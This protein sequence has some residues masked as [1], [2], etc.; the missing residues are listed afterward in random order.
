MA[1]G[2][3]AQMNRFNNKMLEL[4]LTLS[5]DLIPAFMPVI[6]LLKD[7]ADWFAKNSDIMV[8]LAVGLAAVVIGVSAWSFAQGIL[9][10]VMSA[11]PILGLVSLAILLGTF[12]WG[13]VR[14]YEGWGQSLTAIWEVIKAFG[15]MA[16]IPF[17]A[18]GESSWYHIQKLWLN[19]KDFAESV[20]N[21]FT[22]VGT[23]VKLAASG[24]FSGAK[25]AL[26]TNIQT[27]ASRDLI[28]LEAGHKTNQ[29][30]YVNEYLTAQKSMHDNLSKIG[31]TRKAGGSD[32]SLTAAGIASGGSGKTSG[33][34]SGDK[35]DGV[36]GGI[37]GGGPRN[38]YISIGKMVE[39]I[40]VH[41]SSIDKGIDEIEGKVQTV[42]L[43][44]LNSGAAVQ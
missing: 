15:Q 44:I 18:F 11:N 4:K 35:K 16:W 38:I 20:V 21:T 26:T 43:R 27:Q 7:G 17:K 33:M 31:L 3:Q 13:L 42:F 9:N 8:P 23:A 41:A 10:T 32:S 24:D 29:M 37:T 5:N 22:K 25:D 2:P 19:I 30:G 28:A 34:V 39:K 14:R 36:A 6:S 1:Q 12:V 40:E